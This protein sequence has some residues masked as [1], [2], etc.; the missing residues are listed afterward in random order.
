MG[1]KKGVY[2]RRKRKS[3]LNRRVR[4]KRGRNTEGRGRNRWG[5]HV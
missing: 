2:I 1:G 3:D 4:G 5:V